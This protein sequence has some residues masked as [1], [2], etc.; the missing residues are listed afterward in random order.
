VTPEE[1]EAHRAEV[2][3]WHAAR[4]ARLRSPEGWV[5]LSALH[6]L[7]PGPWL[8]GSDAAN[9]LVLVGDGVPARLGRLDV[10]WHRADLVAETGV[11]VDGATVT[12]VELLPDVPG[13]PTVFGVGSLTA[14]LIVRGDRMGLRVRDAHA[15]ALGAFSGI[16]R[17]PV[18]S[19]WRVTATFEP[20]PAEVTLP[21]PDVLGG[22][23]DIGLRGWVSFEVDGT[24]QR[25][26]AVDGG[27]GD[28]WLIFGDATNAGE[29]YPGGRFLYTSP[30]REDGTV[31]VDFNLAYNPPCAFSPFATCPLP[32]PGNR[33][34]VRIPAG[35]LNYAG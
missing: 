9:D 19:R 31:V 2:E 10:G 16:R 12:E 11:T 35:E 26:A 33:L 32:P 4:D 18:D 28:L 29:T 34:A 24:V 14:H 13:P 6:W 3:A 22:T 1:I 30:P 25:L 20:A 15:A 21:V 8:V 7:Q 5:A 27:D 23:E 17:Y